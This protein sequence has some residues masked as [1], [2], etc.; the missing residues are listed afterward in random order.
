M[1]NGLPLGLALAT[2]V[3]TYLPLFILAL[4]ARLNSAG[5]HL[6][7]PFRFLTSD[8]AL[9]VLGS[10]A[11]CEIL[12]QKFP[13]LDNVWDFLHTLLRPVAGAV[14]AG[15]AVNTD[16]I[17]EMAI[18]ML[19]GGALAAGAHSTKT[20][21]R[22]ASTTKSF[23][24]ANPV[25]ALLEDLGVVAASL[26]SIYFPWIM[27]AVVLLFTVVLALVGPRVVRTILFDIRVVWAWFRWLARRLRGMAGPMHL[28]E[29]LLEVGPVELEGLKGRLT[30]E[31]KLYGILPGW[32]RTAR[33]PR[34][35][36]LLV[37]SR[38]LVQVEPRFWRAPKLE[39]FDYA[40]VTLARSSRPGIMARIDLLTRKSDRVTMT[41]RRIHAPFA[42]LAI[43]EI[44]RL[45][46]ALE[47]T[48][49][50]LSPARPA[51]AAVPE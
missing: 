42:E 39:S 33:G 7:P 3:N 21:L 38:R 22:V 41:L 9:I 45:A 34:A 47:A 36:W 24:F 2:G 23:G 50:A 37:T 26:L 20:S 12:A 19:L 8:A 31:E 40:D 11:A 16:R 28:Q 14:A 27:L 51:L 49:E 15:A 4:F 1:T 48:G 29:S 10:L 6:S 46:P 18:V 25:I 32:R 5:V 44:N 17:L 43:K 30:A 35:G 13:G